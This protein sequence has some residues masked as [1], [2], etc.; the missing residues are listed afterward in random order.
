M[1]ACG[2][3]VI[4]LGEQC[5]LPGTLG[6]SYC[7]ES[8]STCDG[9]R[10]GTRSA[11]GDCNSTCGCSLQPFAYSCQLGQCGA[12]CASAQDCPET[13]EKCVGS[14]LATRAPFGECQSNCTCQKTAF[15]E[16]AC[17]KGSCAASC[18]ADTDCSQSTKVCKGGKLGLRSEFAK[19]NI[20]CQCRETLPTSYACTKGECGGQCTVDTDC[21]QFTEVCKSN[22]VGFRSAFGKCTATCECRETLPTSYACV[23]GKCGAQ[24]AV[25]SDCAKNERCT[26]CLCVKRM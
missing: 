2:N 18:S 7:A 3:N 11:F 14:K 24:C 16:P 13:T 5:E 10:Y 22:K 15:S 21:S 17:V 9:R 1:T 20:Y 23:K 19:C 4:D 8:A 25:N 26:G 6:N 12:R